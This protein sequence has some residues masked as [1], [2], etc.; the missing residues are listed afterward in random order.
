MTDQDF[1]N[2]RYWLDLAIKA[3]I[4]VVV[5]IVGLDYRSV[6]NSLSDLEQ[7]KYRVTTEVQIMQSELNHIRTQ[8]ERIEKKLDRVLDK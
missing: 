1:T 4:G 8:I 5:S 2:L 3:I 6:K 7:A